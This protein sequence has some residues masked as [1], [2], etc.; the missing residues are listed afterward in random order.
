MRH[1]NLIRGTVSNNL[2]TCYPHSDHWMYPPIVNLHQ[3]C[4]LVPVRMS[5]QS[6]NATDSIYHLY[7]WPSLGVW[8]SQ[9]S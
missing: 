5:L 6:S 1:S 8:H 3:H 9:S 4:H 2:R 7:P